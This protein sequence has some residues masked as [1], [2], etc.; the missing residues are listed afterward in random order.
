[1]SENVKRLSA[2]LAD[3]IYEKL[4]KWARSENRSLSSLVGFLLERAVR[5]QEQREQSGSKQDPK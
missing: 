1:M 2:Y 4:E 5:E 3:P